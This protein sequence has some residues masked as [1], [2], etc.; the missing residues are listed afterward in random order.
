[1]PPATG[2]QPVGLPGPNMRGPNM[3]GTNMAGACD[4]Q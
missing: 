3:A 4:M 2:F 1:M